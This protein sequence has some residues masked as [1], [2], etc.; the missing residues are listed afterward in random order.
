MQKSEKNASILIWAIFFTI[1]ITFS[2]LA[3][4]TNISKIL[5]DDEVFFAMEEKKILE[6]NFLHDEV[7]RQPFF[8]NQTK[9]F[10]IDL[11][12]DGT[13]TDN[14]SIVLTSLSGDFYYQQFL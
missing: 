11:S 12:P 8:K 7:Y 10:F 4:S 1:L 14:H 2:F 6:K 5:S 3:L 13:V 9:E